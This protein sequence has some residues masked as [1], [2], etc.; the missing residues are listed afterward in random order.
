MNDFLEAALFVVGFLLVLSTV[1]A[2][3]PVVVVLNSRRQ[4]KKLKRRV[5]DKTSLSKVLDMFS[6]SESLVAFALLLP[7]FAL[8]CVLS[9]DSIMRAG[10]ESPLTASLVLVASCLVLAFLL[11]FN[12]L[13]IHH[14]RPEIKKL[15][16]E[17]EGALSARYRRTG[18]IKVV[19]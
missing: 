1:L 19:Q 8:V 12:W 17:M 4:L 11:I 18:P 6:T 13:V 10:D 7:F 15:V 5:V 16:H 9:I 3:R 2:I 14:W